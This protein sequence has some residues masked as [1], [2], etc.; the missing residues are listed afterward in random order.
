MNQAIVFLS[1]CPHC[2]RDQPQDRFTVADLL[3][4]L[5]GAYPI[6]GYCVSCDKFW[7]VGLQERVWLSETI[8]V[9]LRDGMPFEDNDPS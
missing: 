9:L 4:L 1:V 3:K 7:T 2:K 8:A 6:E 5:N